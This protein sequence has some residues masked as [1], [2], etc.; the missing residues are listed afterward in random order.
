MYKSFLEN[1]LL[2]R[3]ILHSDGQ[4]QRTIIWYEDGKRKSES[5]IIAVDGDEEN[6]DLIVEAAEIRRKAFEKE[7]HSKG[8]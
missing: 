7:N 4:V 2:V 3:Y 8:K 1:G 6:L 5:M